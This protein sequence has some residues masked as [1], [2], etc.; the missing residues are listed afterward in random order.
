MKGN[1]GV[2]NSIAFNI[3][4]KI[5]ASIS[6]NKIIRFWN[7]ETKTEIALLEGYNDGVY[8]MAFNSNETILA[9]GSSSEI[10]LWNLETPNQI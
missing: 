1:N 9:S 3:N 10:N 2:V 4:G 7:I 6:N 5:L 8:S